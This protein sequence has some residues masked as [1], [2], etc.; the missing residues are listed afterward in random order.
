MPPIIIHKFETRLNLFFEA[1]EPL[2][3]PLK[4]L[5]LDEF[6]RMFVQFLSERLQ[7]LLVVIEALEASDYG[8]RL[9]TRTAY[10]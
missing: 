3:R 8:V 9:K 1:I 5:R 2:K 10:L 7:S 4:G 6:V